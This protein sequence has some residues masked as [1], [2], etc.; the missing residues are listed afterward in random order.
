MEPLNGSYLVN[1]WKLQI[2]GFTAGVC[3]KDKDL[4]FNRWVVVETSTKAESAQTSS[5]G[6]RV[7]RQNAEVTYI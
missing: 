4:E 2:C 1:N 3:A 5:M 7:R 6:D